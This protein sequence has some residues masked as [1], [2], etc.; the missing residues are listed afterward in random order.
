M[1]IVLLE[2]SIKESA[3]PSS[4]LSWDED[5]VDEKLGPDIM[6]DLFDFISNIV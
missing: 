4:I 2:I 3:L 5:Q 6:I 1:S